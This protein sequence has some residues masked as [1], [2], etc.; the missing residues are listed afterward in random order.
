MAWKTGTT[1]N[2]VFDLELGKK[3]ETSASATRSISFETYIYETLAPADVSAFAQWI[4]N[5]YKTLFQPTNWQDLDVAE[6]EYEIKT[7]TP[8]IVTKAESVGDTIS[9]TA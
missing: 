8:R 9:P 2:V 7:I 4:A 6:D 1:S 3:N 5:N